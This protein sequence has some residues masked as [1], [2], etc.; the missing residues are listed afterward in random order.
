[1]LCKLFTVRL[2]SLVHSRSFEI[3]GKSDTCQQRLIPMVTS[4]GV[5]HL[6]YDILVY[7]FQELDTT[8]LWAAC[9]SSRRLNEL[10]TPLLYKN[11]KVLLRNSDNKNV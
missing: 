1:M 6:P 7:I 10:A 11:V 9:L 5:G 3:S 4:F 2:L 8:S